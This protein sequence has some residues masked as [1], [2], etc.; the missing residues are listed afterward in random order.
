M[1]TAE[2]SVRTATCVHL[3]TESGLDLEGAFSEMVLVH[4]LEPK[5]IQPVAVLDL[6][7]VVANVDSANI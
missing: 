3:T 4:L 5:V 2:H 7:A 6:M 1:A